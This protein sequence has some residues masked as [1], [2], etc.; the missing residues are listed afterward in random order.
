[1]KDLCCAKISKNIPFEKFS[2]LNNWKLMSLT[3]QTVTDMYF[4]YLSWDFF[5]PPRNK[6]SGC[7][8]TPGPTVMC[9][10][11][12]YAGPEFVAFVGFS[13]PWLLLGVISQGNQTNCM[14]QCPFPRGYKS[15]KQISKPVKS[16]YK[17]RIPIFWVKAWGN[18]LWPSDI[19]LTT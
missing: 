11:S 2:F 10:I 16:V 6:I 17:I 5:F 9:G 3:S 1:M 19:I 15:E 13:I 14:K 7:F 4:N 8:V 12:S 18:P